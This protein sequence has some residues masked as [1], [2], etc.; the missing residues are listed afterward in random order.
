MKLALIP[1]GE[2]LMGS[3]N[4]ASANVAQDDEKPQ[5]RV[6]ITKPF[7]LGVYEVTQAE[8][9]KVMGS[10]PSGFKTSNGSTPVEM[11]SWDD[12]VAFC[13]R[14]SE[15]AEERT[16]GRRY[17]LLTEAEWEYACQAGSTTMFSFGNSA[18]KLRNYAWYKANS[19]SKTHP[20][21]QKK[22]NA[23]GLYDM[24]GN[25]LEWCDDWKGG[26]A[27]GTVADPSG[28]VSGVVRVNRGGAFGNSTM[29]SRSA[30][31]SSHPPESRLQHIG[32]RLALSPSGG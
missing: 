12:A 28:P 32:F 26:Y 30:L 31:R 29:G 21:G 4:S 17:R 10:N 13:Q 23:W 14:L 22:P 8:Y 2:F 16:A 15:T 27:S 5:H 1:A 6:R 9:Q 24:H 19:D 11:V 18:D 25:V 20:V 3:P 7:Y